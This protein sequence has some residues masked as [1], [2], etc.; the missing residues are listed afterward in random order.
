MTSVDV[1][2]ISLNEKNRDVATSYLVRHKICTEITDQTISP[3]IT[4]SHY[5]PWNKPLEAYNLI[6]TDMNNM[7][8]LES[9]KMAVPEPKLNNFDLAVRDAGSDEDD[10]HYT[11]CY[12][13]YSP[14]HEKLKTVYKTLKVEYFHKIDF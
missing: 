11:Y 1:T 5:C 2:W 4:D 10:K 12:K 13:I 14:D 6:A 9:Y 3:S 8:N 7:T